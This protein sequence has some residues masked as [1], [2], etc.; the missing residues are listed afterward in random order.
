[1]NRD[2]PDPM[3][4]GTGGTSAFCTAQRTTVTARAFAVI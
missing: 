1:M 4:N 3:K 2:P